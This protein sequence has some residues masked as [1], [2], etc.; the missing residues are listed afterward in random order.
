MSSLPRCRNCGWAQARGSHAEGTGPQLAARGDVAYYRG[1]QTCGSIWT[2]PVCGAK[3]RN[4]RSDEI[5]RFCAA[6][7]G[8]GNSVYMVTLTA[9]HDLAMRLALLLSMIANSYR[10]VISGRPWTRLKDALGIIGTIRALEVTCG[11]NGWHPHL[12]TLVF[13]EGQADALAPLHLYFADRWARF[14][15]GTCR[16]CGKRIRKKTGICS[17][18]GKGYRRPDPV[19]GVKVVKCYAPAEAGE[20][21][22]KT[23]DGKNPGHEMARSDMKSGTSEHR[24]PFEILADFMATGDKDHLNLWHEYEKATKGHQAITW[25]PALVKLRKDLLDVDDKTDDEIVEQE[26]DGEP[27]ADITK[28]AMRYMA[29]VPGLRTAILDAYELGGIGQVAEVGRDYGLLLVRMPDRL[30]RIYRMRGRQGA[31]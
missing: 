30:P 2:C 11:C 14:V 4:Y 5:S 16:Q 24:T 15:T 9:P 23:Q 20:Y 21:I 1:V 7:I 19:H 25:S 31:G 22:C 10:S 28:G 18:G 17:C 27:V 8:K 6:W 3:I 12:H 26:V 13:I 29:K